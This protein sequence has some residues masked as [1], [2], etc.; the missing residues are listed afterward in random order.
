MISVVE[1]ERRVT[2]ASIFG[3]IIGKFC[4]KKKQ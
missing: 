1:L 2:N 4:H 3:T